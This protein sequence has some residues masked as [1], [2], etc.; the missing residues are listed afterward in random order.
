MSYFT[1]DK[2]I[3]RTP[4]LKMSDL[5]N[6]EKELLE[7]YKT[8]TVREAL[9][10]GSPDLYNELLKVENS[11]IR[12]NDKRRKV[13]VSLY[14]Y[15]T[16]MCT[17]CTPFGMFAGVSI[18][19][20]SK[21]TEVSIGN[22]LAFKSR[23]DMDYLCGLFYELNKDEATYPDLV[24]YP[25][26]SL[27]KI[28]G[29]WRYV[30]YAFTSN[31]VR[32]HNLILID[33]NEVLSTLIDRA[34]KGLTYNEL[35][36]IVLA[37]EFSDKESQE[38]LNELIKNQIL[39]SELYPS[40]SGE[41]YQIRLCNKLQTLAKGKYTD[42]YSS[43]IE[44]MKDCESNIIKA[45]QILI[46]KLFFYG[47][48]VRP[49]H[50]VQVDLLKKPNV[51]RVETFI[52]EKVYK[53]TKILQQFTKTPSNESDYLNKF[54]LA[55]Y[56]R[57]ENRFMPLSQVLDVDIGIGYKNALSISRSVA[58]N[59]GNSMLRDKMI[60][61]VKQELFNLSLKTG[62]KEIAISSELINNLPGF[63]KPLSSTF[64][65]IGQFFYNEKEQLLFKYK[66]AG[67]S[68][69]VNLFG[70][71]GHLHSDIDGLAKEIS[72]FERNKFN[73]AI[74]G[75]IVHL[76]QGRI[77]NILM[78]PHYRNYEIP[79]LCHSILPKEFQIDIKD[80]FV[81]LVN[82]RIV[83]YSE[84]LECE[85]IPR[86]ATA[87]NF[88]LDS[89][90]IYHFLCDLQTQNTSAGITWSWDDLSE[91]NFLPGVT[92]DNIILASPRWN[93][94][95]SI[96]RSLK[97]DTHDW[98]KYREI[99]NA[100]GI[101]SQIIILQG[102]N[103]LY[104]DLDS[105]IG[106]ETFLSFCNKDERLVIEEFL[107]SS[108]RGIDGFS[109]E[110]IIPIFTE[111]VPSREKV[112]PSILGPSAR[113]QFSPS[114]EWFFLKIYTG[115]KFGEFLLT[116][117]I[118]DLIE[119]LKVQKFIDKWFF[120][121]YAD[122][123]HHLRLRFH[124]TDTECYQAMLS[125]VHKYLEQFLY[126][127][128]I[129]DLQVAIYR[130]EIER[131]GATTIEDCE[132]WFCYNSELSLNLISLFRQCSPTEQVL[133]CLTYIDFLLSQWKFT[134]QD[135]GEICERQLSLFKKEFNVDNNQ[136]LRKTLNNEYRQVYNEFRMKYAENLELYNVKFEILKMNS[137]KTSTVINAI[138]EK[139]MNNGGKNQ[140]IAASFIHMFVNRIF[141][142]NQRFKEMTLYYFISKFYDSK[143]FYGGFPIKLGIGMGGLKALNLDD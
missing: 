18:G 40:I 3:M 89:L 96:F 85:I 75:E 6:N 115:K 82:S 45:T 121:R 94:Q 61:N 84:K 112:L 25:N 56:E 30:E 15:Y 50:L 131:Y 11:Q 130:P 9:F 46:K 88:N 22:S 138:R 132:L 142:S 66:S 95:T 1:A 17:R 31:N 7:A 137:E 62:D 117:I 128:T 29:K 34:Q 65:F 49:N 67:G 47:A 41:E 72:S 13:L 103:E 27:Y 119:H 14:K 101:P 4:L 44:W 113:G 69:A 48:N 55:F 74:I 108:K 92:Y 23:L 114:S 139:Q 97:N 122:P 99:L 2:F 93:I 63:V 79:Y 141:P 36:K 129:W 16:R 54:K 35:T 125:I 58:S 20:F 136:S 111:N 126:D 64:S 57:F 100:K 110:I 107:Y 42:L 120:I 91:Q 78:R 109:S 140:E 37:F 5:V 21:K 33:D 73:N 32:Y 38:Y 59:Q 98:N 80:L 68:S 102:D 60:R 106:I 71:F 70:R 77:G 134:L 83:L 104:I 10:V 127:N 51:C 133:Y 81:G 8:S 24:F 86:M 105:D 26:T 76:P 124:L 90:P 143:N 116:D 12:E 19:E 52:K 39:C 28:H 53:S 118:P 135:K 87:H 123:H 43:L